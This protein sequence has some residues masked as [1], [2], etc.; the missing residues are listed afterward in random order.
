MSWYIE[1][2]LRHRDEIKQSIIYNTPIVIDKDELFYCDN[3]AIMIE[4]EYDEELYA[5]EAE[6]VDLDSDVY[7]DILI[8]EKLISNLHKKN[9]LNNDDIL[10]INSVGEGTFFQDIA[11]SLGLVRET[12]SRRFIKICD[13]LD[14]YSHGIYS[15]DTIIKNLKEEKKLTQEQVDILEKYIKSKWKNKLMRKENK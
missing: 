13:C 1:Y 9:I 12:V 2:L 4:Y 3:I 5:S 14:E 7:N 8:L 15:D 11:V 10:L 6:I